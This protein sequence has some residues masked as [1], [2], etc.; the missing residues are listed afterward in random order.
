MPTT[1][2]EISE[3]DHANYAW[4]KPKRVENVNITETIDVDAHHV[5]GEW[6]GERDSELRELGEQ[7]REATKCDEQRR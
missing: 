4:I 3:V 2:L 6:A 7:E 5:V 1:T